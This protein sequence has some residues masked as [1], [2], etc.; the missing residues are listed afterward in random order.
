MSVCSPAGDVTGP[1]VRQQEALGA[2]RLQ[3]WLRVHR[4][5]TCPRIHQLTDQNR[6][7]R[8]RLNKRL[9][10]LDERVACTCAGA[11]ILTEDV[12]KVLQ[13]RAAV[14][15]M[16]AEFRAQKHGIK[17]FTRTSSC[18]G[19][20]EPPRPRSDAL[21]ACPGAR[22]PPLSWHG[23]VT[24]R[25][26]SPAAE[27]VLRGPAYVR[28]HAA[29]S[30]REGVIWSDW[31]SS[32]GPDLDVTVMSAHAHSPGPVPGWTAGYHGNYQ[33]CKLCTGLF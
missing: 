20:R 17:T 11:L 15:S 16:M 1:P 13:R 30:R 25:L 4:P 14:H 6:T 5:F 24:T 12:E 2:P 3:T 21:C 23:L 7:S 8:T 26:Y 18:S 33:L 32:S 9:R 22:C 31:T 27:D 28:A 10:A 19:V 29:R